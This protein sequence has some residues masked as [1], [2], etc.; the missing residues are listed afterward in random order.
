MHKFDDDFYG[1]LLKVCICGYIRPEMNFDSLDAL[2]ATINQ[3]IA[4]ATESL[5]E[6]KYAELKS[7]DFFRAAA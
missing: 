4:Q 6:P 2:I 1:Q 7:C 5:E 3:D